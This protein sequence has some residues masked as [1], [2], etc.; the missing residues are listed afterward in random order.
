MD[1][2]AAIL[3]SIAIIIGVIMLSYL[4]QDKE[5]PKGLP[6]LH[7]CAA[8][9][10]IILLIIYAFTTESEH[11]HW[12]SIVI[13]LVA[14]LGG[15][16]LFERDITRQKVPKSIAIIHALIALSAFGWMVYH[17]FTH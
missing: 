2:I 16:F 5:I 6:L 17:L 14:V 1:I 11:K 4:L 15:L 10:G 8:G 12:G 9:A 7:G 3:L 13:F